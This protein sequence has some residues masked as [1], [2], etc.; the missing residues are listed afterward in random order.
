MTITKEYLDKTIKQVIESDERD[1]MHEAARFH[2]WEEGMAKQ[3][4]LLK[5]LGQQD[6]YIM[7]TED[8]LMP[9]RTISIT[10]SSDLAAEIRKLSNIL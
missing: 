5:W 4:K 10:V 2:A 1:A 3:A 8:K 7:F 9:P 6:R